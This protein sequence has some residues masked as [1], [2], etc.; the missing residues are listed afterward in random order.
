MAN[1]RDDGDAAGGHLA[2]ERFVIEGG[3]VFDAASATGHDDDIDGEAG[4]R[5]LLGDARLIRA[6]FIKKA[7]P[8]RDFGNGAPP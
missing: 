5:R 1:G 7:Q 3:E 4:E 6:V 2:C 8:G